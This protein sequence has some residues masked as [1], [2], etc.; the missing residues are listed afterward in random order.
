MF[1][2]R[3]VHLNYSHTTRGVINELTLGVKEKCNISS[4]CE[5]ECKADVLFANKQ[6]QSVFRYEKYVLIL[7]YGD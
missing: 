1:E 2:E 5:A 3:S 7:G 4:F 6:K